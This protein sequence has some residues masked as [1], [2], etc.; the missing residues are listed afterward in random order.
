MI[1]SVVPPTNI[2]RQQCSLLDHWNHPMFLRWVPLT[3]CVSVLKSHPTRVVYNYH[4]D[5]IYIYIYTLYLYIYNDI[6][7]ISPGNQSP[8]VSSPH[9]PHPFRV[10]LTVFCKR[11]GCLAIHRNMVR[12][13]RFA[14]V[15]LKGMLRLSKQRR[16]FGVKK[17]SL[18]DP[19]RLR[20]C[21]VCVCGFKWTVSDVYIYNMY[22]YV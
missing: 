17:Q 21:V 16:R 4:T 1:H 13:A 22:V 14:L 9:S 15:H 12:A 18:F 3:C 11:P 6:S 20:K 7:I 5:D 19:R 10:Q 8:Y 2:Y